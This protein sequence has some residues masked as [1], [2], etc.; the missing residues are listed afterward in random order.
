MESLL[1]FPN[2]ESGMAQAILSCIFLF[3]FNNAYN[4]AMNTLHGT[5]PEF[6]S[7]S[8]L[9][10]LSV[11]GNEL[12]YFLEQFLLAIFIGRSL[13]TLACLAAQFHHEIMAFVQIYIILP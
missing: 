10:A 6:I 2:W 12:G 8:T 1:M 13:Y 7:N 4:A 5:P 3:I 11:A 9:T